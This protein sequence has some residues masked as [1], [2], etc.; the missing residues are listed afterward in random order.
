MKKNNFKIVKI[1]KIK[2]LF[3]YEKKILINDLILDLKLGYYDHEKKNLK[4][5]NLVS[6]LTMKIKTFE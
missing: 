4:K 6:K 5:L 1:N 3:N 2:N